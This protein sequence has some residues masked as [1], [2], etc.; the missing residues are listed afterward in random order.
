MKK[1]LIL[2]AFLLIP[3]FIS[4]QFVDRTLQVVKA[5]VQLQK[6]ELK[7][8]V[9]NAYYEARGEGVVG[10]L[11]VTK[12]VINRAVASKTSYCSVVYKRKQFSWTE[13]T[14]L[15]TIS[16]KDRDAIEV[17][18]LD[19]VNGDLNH[20]IPKQLLNA[21]FYHNTSVQP[22]WTTSVKRLGSWNNHVFYS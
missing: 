6:S 7:C 3:S 2:L 1:I 12:V 20:V 8:L 9:D 17:L 18:I 4:T 10:M 19:L 11:L 13:N 21:V 22:Y 16:K 15:R 5:R 14:Y